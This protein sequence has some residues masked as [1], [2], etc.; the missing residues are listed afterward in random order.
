MPKPEDIKRRPSRTIQELKNINYKWDKEKDSVLYT[1]YNMSKCERLFRPFLRWKVR[2]YL[3][4]FRT[5]DDSRDSSTSRA[6]N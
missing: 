4:Y 1:W 2:K 6:E 5:R 3:K